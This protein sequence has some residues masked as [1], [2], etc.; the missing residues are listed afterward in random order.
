MHTLKETIPNQVHIWY[1]KD[2]LWNMGIYTTWAMAFPGI[3][4]CITSLYILFTNIYFEE[5]HFKMLF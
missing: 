3:R 5:L 1:Y 4:F 2:E